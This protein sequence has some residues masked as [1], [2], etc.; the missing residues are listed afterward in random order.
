MMLKFDMTCT[1][2]RIFQTGKNFVST[3]HKVGGR[4]MLR[5]MIKLPFRIIAAPVWLVLAAV[6]IVLVFL[7][8]LSAGFCYLI[9]GISVVT[10]V[11]SIGFGIGTDWTMKSAILTTVVFVLLPHIGMGIVA[12]IEVVKCGLQDFIFG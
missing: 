4:I 11:L 7:V 6:N 9:A 5:F 3:G 8:G 10:E 1:G 2:G 12:V